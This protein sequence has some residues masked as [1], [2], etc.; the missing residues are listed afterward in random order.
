MT[1]LGQYKKLIKGLNL[2][3]QTNSKFL[4]LT[5][6][7]NQL[8]SDANRFLSSKLS[9]RYYFGSGDKDSVIDF[10]SYTFRGIKEVE[11]LVKKAK[12]ELN[13]M[14]GAKFCNLNCF[15]GLHAM[16]C[17]ILVSTAPN[18]T[19]MSLKFEDGGHSATKGI[20]ENLG[21][22]HVFAVFDLNKL[23]FNLKQTLDVV[24]KFKVKTIYI[25]IS[26]HINS[27]DIKKLRKLLPKNVTIVYDASHSLGLI[28]GGLMESPLKQGAD[29]VCSNTHKTFAGPQG[30][31]ILFKDNKFGEKSSF[32]IDTTFV[33]SVNTGRLISLSIAILE[34]VAYG[35][36]YAT[37]VLKNS[38]E[39]AS[40][41]VKFGYE[42]RKSKNNSYSDNEQVHVFID[43]SGSKKEMF[44]NLLKNYISTNFMYVLGG[45]LFARIGTQEITKRGF[46][47]KDMEQI[48]KL[49][50]Q[51]LRGKNVKSL[52][53]KISKSHQKI[54]YSFNFK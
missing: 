48:A 41:F 16:M 11:Q 45:R 33:S 4:H 20:V 1:T 50:D 38:R 46:I 49:F 22:K 37:T 31:L 25:D 54:K 14:S 35:K 53:Q 40:N 19:V 5:V 18:D 6:N 3:E 7:E 15:S 36:K 13:E 26:V 30:G 34:Y 52:V 43:K 32:I 28:L 42:V 29:I 51:A 24:K 2:A 9:E 12:E 23:D 8:S 44:K 17:A 21:R 27:L 47:P 39:L 10:G